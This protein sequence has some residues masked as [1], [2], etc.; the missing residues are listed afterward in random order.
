MQIR[1][2]SSQTDRNVSASLL[3]FLPTFRPCFT[4]TK[5]LLKVSAAGLWSDQRL[6]RIWQDAECLMAR[7]S[8][9]KT[10]AVMLSNS[11]TL[12]QSLFANLSCW[13][14]AQ[15]QRKRA[16]DAPLIPDFCHLSE[17]SGRRVLRFR[18]LS[19]MVRSTEERRKEPQQHIPKETK[20]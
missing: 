7:W 9:T 15:H 2:V 19:V 16:E 4:S 17:H 20:R 18:L 10:S 6:E 12:V 1:F 8:Q 3:L 5:W 14:D 13:H 11:R